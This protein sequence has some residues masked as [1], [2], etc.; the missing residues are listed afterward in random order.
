M[1]EIKDGLVEQL[2]DAKARYAAS[3]ARYEE[4]CREARQAAEAID[5]EIVLLIALIEKFD[6]HMKDKT[7]AFP[8]VPPASG[9][10][11]NAPQRPAEV[12][13][14]AA[15]ISCSRCGEQLTQHGNSWVD[16]TGFG[17]C[18]EDNVRH[19]AV[20]SNGGRVDQQPTSVRLPA[21]M[22]PPRPGPTTSDP[23]GAHPAADIS[24][25]RPDEPK[26]GAS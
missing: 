16:G 22:V 8:V 25:T 26:G 5:A 9:P 18:G 6:E 4:I 19:H 21:E 15:V 11:Q 20:S 14:P 13:P 24:A 7:R 12:F 1:I 17:T 2:E 23:G 10:I 3:K